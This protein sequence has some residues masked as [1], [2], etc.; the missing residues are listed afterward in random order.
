MAEAM[1]RIS[2]LFFL[3]HYASSHL[4]IAVHITVVRE[5]KAIVAIADGIFHDILRRILTTLCG[6][7]SN[8]HDLA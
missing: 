1:E 7:G 2:S 8:L 6:D 4:G 3:F 5:V